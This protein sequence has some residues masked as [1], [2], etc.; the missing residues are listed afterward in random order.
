MR[1]RPPHRPLGA[2]ELFCAG[3]DEDNWQGTAED[4]DIEPKGP[5]VDVLEVKAHPIF[6]VSDVASATDLPEARDSRLHA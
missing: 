2:N 4:F 5:V 1:L 6:E 3:S